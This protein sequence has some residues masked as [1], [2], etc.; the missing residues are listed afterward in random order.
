MA[1][2][3]QRNATECVPY[4]IRAGSCY[5]G[6]NQAE[7]VLGVVTWVSTRPLLEEIYAGLAVSVEIES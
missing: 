5:L 6:L 3:V 7:F 2:Q 1:F 4:R